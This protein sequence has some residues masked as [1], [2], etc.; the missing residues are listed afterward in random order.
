MKGIIGQV[1]GDS[2]GQYYA[3]KPPKNYDF[4]FMYD[5]THPSDDSICMI[6]VADWLMN[7]D[8]SKNALIDKFHYWGNKY[9]YGLWNYDLETTFKKWINEKRREPYNSFGNGSAMRVPPVGWYAK[10]LDE[11]LELAKI[12]AEVTHNHPEGIKGA[13]AIAG[14]IWLLRNENFN[15]DQIMKWVSKTFGYNLSKSYAELKRTHKFECTCQNS[16]PA[17]F[18]SWYN[19]KNYEDCIRKTI[20]LGGDT[21][22]EGGLAGALATATPGMEVD[23]NFVHEVTRFFTS[24]FMHLY[25]DFHK[26]YE[27]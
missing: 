24:E 1:I 16:V 3:Q 2:I 11:C 17:I 19:S 8:K 25:D 27:A 4:D 10:S 22:T 18:I 5:R 23:D 15:K 12:S 20:S 13:Q 14:A 9:N 7:T 6:A 26:K 21:D